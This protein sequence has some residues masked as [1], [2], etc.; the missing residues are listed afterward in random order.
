MIPIML[1]I[2]YEVEEISSTSHGGAAFLSAH[3]DGFKMMADSN[4]IRLKY[5]SLL[6]QLAHSFKRTRLGLLT[7]CCDMSQSPPRV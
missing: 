2:C 1:H 3:D 6:A 5:L 4:S 7:S